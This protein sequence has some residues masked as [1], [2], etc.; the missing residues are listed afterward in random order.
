MESE[1][2]ENQMPQE[3]EL[4][5]QPKLDGEGHSFETAMQRL[6]QI[7]KQLENGD[8]SLEDSIERFQEGMKLSKLCRDKLDQAEQKIEM[9]VAQGDTYV[10]KTFSPEE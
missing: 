3:T 8:L 4:S 5:P 7:V 10:R 9:L 1:M 2:R 6:E